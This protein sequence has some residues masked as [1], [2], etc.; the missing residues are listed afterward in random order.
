ME[1]RRFV[2]DWKHSRSVCRR[3]S[4]LRFL[5][6]FGRARQL[7]LDQRSCLKHGLCSCRVPVRLGVPGR[8][9]AT[10]L[11]LFAH[12]SRR[13]CTFRHCSCRRARPLSLVVWQSGLQLPGIR[14]RARGVC[15][16][17]VLARSIPTWTMLEAGKSPAIRHKQTDMQQ[18]TSSF[19]R[20]FDVV[21]IPTHWS[22][23]GDP[24]TMF[25]FETEGK[26]YYGVRVPGH[27]EVQSGMKVT[28]LLDKQDDWRVVIGWVNHSSGEIARPLIR[29]QIAFLLMLLLGTWMLWEAQSNPD[30]GLIVIFLGLMLVAISGWFLLKF[31]RVNA[32]LNTLARSLKPVLE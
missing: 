2:C 10:H 24:S 4:G 3:F 1:A 21:R 5:D 26:K 6:Q 19:G 9:I 32:R 27:P 25:S 20:V 30:G 28:A 23:Q 14:P 13:L 31:R 16:G 12:G 17:S 22:Q 18:V 29:N 15:R 8:G 7:G 11:L